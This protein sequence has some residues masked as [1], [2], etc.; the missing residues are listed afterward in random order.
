MLLLVYYN[1]LISLDISTYFIIINYNNIY[2][3]HVVTTYIIQHFISVNAEK[4]MYAI[5]R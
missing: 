1:W 4:Q 3:Y 5:N 2:L